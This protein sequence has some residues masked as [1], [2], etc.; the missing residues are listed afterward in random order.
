MVNARVV[1]YDVNLQAIQRSVNRMPSY[2][3]TNPSC[4]SL[5][6]SSLDAAICIVCEYTAP[7]RF[8]DIQYRM[9]NDSVGKVWQSVYHSLLRFMDGKNVILRC[10]ER[11]IFQHLMQ[12]Q[13]IILSILIEHSHTIGISLSLPSLFVS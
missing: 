12:L 11:L 2:N 8:K 5:Y 9:V 6:S 7:Y 3:L 1:F 4:A 10:S 13:Q